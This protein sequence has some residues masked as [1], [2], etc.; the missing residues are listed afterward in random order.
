MLFN[1]YV[2][3]N[4]VLLHSIIVAIQVFS[5]NKRV[6][7]TFKHEIRDFTGISKCLGNF[8]RASLFNTQVL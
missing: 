5:M 2:K 3:Q 4:T 6:D 7:Y 1:Q 8:G